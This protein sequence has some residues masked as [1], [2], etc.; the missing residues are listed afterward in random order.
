MLASRPLIGNITEMMHYSFPRVQSQQMLARLRLGSTR[1]PPK[2]LQR[3][4]TH[5]LWKKFHSFHG[6]PLRYPLSPTGGALTRAPP[7]RPEDERKHFR[8]V[9]LPHHSHPPAKNIR[10]IQLVIAPPFLCI[11]QLFAGIW[12]QILFYI[13]IFFSLSIFFLRVR[14]PV[15]SCRREGS[16][17]RSNSTPSLMETLSTAPE[18]P[19][20]WHL[21]SSDFENRAD[22]LRQMNYH[23]VWS[24]GKLVFMYF[25][26]AR[27]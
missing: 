9:C 2:T 6:C 25:L 8:D 23:S 20:K 19:S 24:L 21:S 26:H 13:L 14:Q 27:V 11:S 5:H 3:C 18:P 7:R 1:P 12:S 4:S 16:Q 15:R 10:S 17:S 22:L